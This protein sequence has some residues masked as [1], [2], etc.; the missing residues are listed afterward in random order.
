M[1]LHLI[2]GFLGSGKTTSIIGLSKLL[3][4]EGN[5]VAVITNDQG[6]FLVD[7]AFIRA[8][9]IP[10]MEVQ[11]GCFC[12]NYQDMIQQLDELKIKIDPDI[13]FAEAIGSAGNLV[14]TVMQPLLDS[15]DY[16]VT[17]LSAV[18]DA[19]LL[20]RLL[21]NEYLPFSDSVNSTLISQL[22]ESDYLI[23]NKIDLLPQ[24][25]IDEIKCQLPNAFPGKTAHFQ[26]AFSQDDLALCY[27]LISSNESNISPDIDFNLDRHQQA[28]SRLKWF[29]KVQDFNSA[30]NVFPEIILVLSKFIINLKRHAS[31]IAHMK[32]IIYFNDQVIKFS[33]TSFEDEDWQSEL[34]TLSCTTARMILNVRVQSDEDLEAL[35][36]EAL[37]KQD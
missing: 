10:V 13:V 4:A 32:A 30:E 11:S 33:I 1:D 2:T 25:D 19:R 29:E 24:K 7:T 31:I 27:A 17:S 15:S 37:K 14:A 22:K 5:K 21:R 18:I 8:S 6:K 34:R 28:L 20:L 12:S 23:I 36:L 16:H 26:S 35:F 3:M 9:D